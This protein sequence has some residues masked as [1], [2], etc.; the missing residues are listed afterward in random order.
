MSLSGLTTGVWKALQR[1][2]PL[3][4]ADDLPM[5]RQLDADRVAAMYCRARDLE[6]EAGKVAWS[7]EQ[8]LLEKS[9]DADGSQSLIGAL[10]YVEADGLDELMIPP[11]PPCDCDDVCE[12]CDTPFDYSVVGRVVALVDDGSHVL[13]ENAPVGDGWLY[14]Y[15]CK[16]RGI[17]GLVAVSPVKIHGFY[18]PDGREIIFETD[19]ETGEMARV[20]VAA[21]PSEWVLE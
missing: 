17:P 15:L 18:L 9:R 3:K 5:A 19:E 4:D 7:L 16:M 10:V 14:P 11:P 12:I 21:D 13:V 1:F 2:L 6:L 8:V 20:G